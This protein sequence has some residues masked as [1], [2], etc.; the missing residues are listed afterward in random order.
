M[1]VKPNAQSWMDNKTK[2]A[3]LE[4][5]EA[6]RKAYQTLRMEGKARRLHPGE[7]VEWVAPSKPLVEH[8]KVEIAMDFRGL[9]RAMK[10]GKS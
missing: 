4:H 2:G 8:S 9:I 3:A 6:T 5:A 1:E 7:K 10:E